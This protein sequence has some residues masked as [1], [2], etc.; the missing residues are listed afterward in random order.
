MLTV[1]QMII[2]PS[3]PWQN[4]AEC[5]IKELKKGA[6]R[7]LLLTN[8]PWRLWDDCF[9]YKAYVR[10]HMAHDIFKLDREVPKTI[11]SGETANISQFS[12][13]AGTNG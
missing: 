9:K 12:S 10:S 7:K 6:G 5:K 11:M 2:E 13:L 8:M 1:S 3:S 4:A